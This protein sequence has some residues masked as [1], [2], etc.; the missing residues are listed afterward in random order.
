MYEVFLS[1]YQYDLLLSL[2]QARS[3]DCQVKLLFLH[4]LYLLELLRM[5]A[6]CLQLHSKGEVF[7]LVL[8]FSSCLGLVFWEVDAEVEVFSSIGREG[9]SIAVSERV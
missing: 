8:F 1:Q 3:S 2:S 4:Q 6:G 5:T 9:G 7:K